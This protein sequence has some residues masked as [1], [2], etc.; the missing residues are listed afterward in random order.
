[1]SGCHRTHILQSLYGLDLVGHIWS[2]SQSA[3]P[4]RG[5]K[6]NRKQNKGEKF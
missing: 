5:R 1:M 6:P 3:G 2:Q 4:S